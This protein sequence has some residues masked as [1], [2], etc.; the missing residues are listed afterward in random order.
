MPQRVRKAVLP[1][2]GLGTRFL[3]AT[4]A[5][6]KEMLT[7]VD[8]PLIQYAV[9]ECLAAGIEEFVFVTGRNKSAIEDHFDAA[10]ELEATLHE[11]GKKSELKQTQDAA[12][13]PGNAIFTRQQRPLVHSAGIG[14]VAAI[15]PVLHVREDVREDAVDAVPP[16]QPDRTNG[17][18]LGHP[19]QRRQQPTGG[20]GEALVGVELQHPWVS[21]EPLKRIALRGEV[22]GERPGRH[23]HGAT[24][25]TRHRHRPR[26]S[27]LPIEQ[28]RDV[29]GPARLGRQARQ[30]PVTFG[31]PAEQAEGDRARLRTIQIVE[32]GPS[33]VL[34]VRMEQGPTPPGVE[35]AEAAPEPGR[36]DAQRIEVEPVG[37][38]PVGDE[39]RPGQGLGQ[40][41]AAAGSVRMPVEQDAAGA[42]GERK[43]APPPI[44]KG[45]VPLARVQ[46]VGGADEAPAEGRHVELYPLRSQAH[47]DAP[48]QRPTLA[49]P[50]TIPP[51]PDLRAR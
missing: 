47:P 13:K 26:R 29:I 4:K 35:R 7:V 50:R 37:R 31:R 16:R 41:R 48:N 23:P 28:D 43:G 34:H 5:M 39:D 9:E 18:G 42:A 6:P 3:P 40:V 2:A 32:L 21:G 8:R 45:E 20:E 24:R 36:G 22:V 30:H 46:H 51:S 10:Y 38:L 49:V 15:E 14:H 12:I 25:E 1:V 33:G 11:R 19:R 17:A 27:R 44:R